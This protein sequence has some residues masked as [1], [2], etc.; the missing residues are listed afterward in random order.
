MTDIGNCKNRGHSLQ[1]HEPDFSTGKVS[2]C[3]ECN[4]EGYYYPI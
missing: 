4:C 3:R 2:K 1:S